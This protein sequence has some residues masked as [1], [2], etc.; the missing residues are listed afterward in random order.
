VSDDKGRRS[1]AVH[2]RE[3]ILSAARLALTESA[4]VSLNAVAKRAGVAN[5]TL[6]RHFPTREALILSVYREE[7]RRLVEAA[8]E[9]LAELDPA[10][11]LEAWVSALAQYAMT[12]RGLASALQAA[13]SPTTEMFPDVYEPIVGA[14]ERM[15]R[16]AEDAGVVRPGIRADEVILLLAGLFQID[17]DSD[18]RAQSVRLYQLALVGLRPDS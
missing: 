14:L 6:Y 18:W 12:K 11:A 7:V 3:A 2:N 9:L 5:A 15:L 17:P 10:E 4:D 8:D 16:A 1:D 13:T